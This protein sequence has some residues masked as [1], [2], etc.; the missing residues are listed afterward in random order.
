MLHSV[1]R[2]LEQRD[3]TLGHGDRVAALAE[4]V[5][6]ALGWD[7]ER[8]QGLRFAAPLHDVGKVKVPPQLLG[9]PARSRSRSSRRSGATRRP[10]PSSSCRFAGPTARSHMSSSTTS[11]GTATGTRRG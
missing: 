7:R 4:P 5:A 6:T 1:A 9:K 2:A 11:A 8:I 3:Q 10:A